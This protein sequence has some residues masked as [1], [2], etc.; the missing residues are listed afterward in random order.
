MASFEEFAQKC[1]AQG[2]ELH[3]CLALPP[4]VIENVSAGPEHPMLRALATA[5]ALLR[6][7]PNEPLAT[8]D[9]LL[10]LEAFG[11][12]VPMRT[13]ATMC[14]GSVNPELVPPEDTVALP[15]PLSYG[16]DVC[17]SAEGRW[18]AALESEG[19]KSGRIITTYGGIA[20]FFT[21]DG[22][23]DGLVAARKNIFEQT[24]MTFAKTTIGGI[25]YPAGSLLNLRAV[26]ETE[27]AHRKNEIHIP[28][29][30]TVR[31][32]GDVGLA[33][34]M[35]LSAFALPQ[36]Q[37]AEYGIAHLTQGYTL[38]DLRATATAAGARARKAGVR[39][40]A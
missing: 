33:T 29:G 2:V 37:Q 36:N 6:T 30:Y 4:T 1:S 22:K 17:Y 31:S 14:N 13:L 21:A 38:E 5:G 24:T 32:L 19:A 18:I 16:K 23:Q 8:N 15:G 11:D 7:K 35:R 12:D 9:M 10:D 40:V 20:E 39:A 26:G 34:F 28:A 3:P 25:A 27:N